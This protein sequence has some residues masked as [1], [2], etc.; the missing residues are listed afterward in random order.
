MII[1]ATILIYILLFALIV[2]FYLLA[3]NERVC[4][5]WLY[6]LDL[7]PNKILACIKLTEKYSYDR[8]LFSFKPL[9]LECWFTEEELRT[10]E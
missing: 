1:L 8:M 7:N 9:R 5:F 2:S 3:R 4:A 10:I 6:I